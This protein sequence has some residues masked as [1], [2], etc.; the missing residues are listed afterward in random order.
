MHR[1]RRCAH[2]DDPFRIAAML[3][4][5][6]AQIIDGGGHIFAARGHIWSGARR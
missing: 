5:M 4:N 3:R 2:D 1:A 6:G